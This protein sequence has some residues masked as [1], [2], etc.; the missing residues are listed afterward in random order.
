MTGRSCHFAGFAV[1][2]S[3]TA[4]GYPFLAGSS[5]LFCTHPVLVSANFGRLRHHGSCSA[6]SEGEIFGEGKFG[7]SIMLSVLD[8]TRV[9]RLLCLG[10]HCDDIEIGAG[11][12]IMRLAKAHPEIEVKWVILAG[13]DPVRVEEARRSAKVFLAGTSR[14]EVS[15][16]RKSVV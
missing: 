14:S 12:T 15:I 11:G 6:W 4:K 8:L 7:W 2:I 16:D 9:K 3:M 13:E 10:A 1:P 5:H